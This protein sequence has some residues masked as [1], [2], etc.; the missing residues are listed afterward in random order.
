MICS[1]VARG[2]AIGQLPNNFKVIAQGFFEMLLIAQCQKILIH[3][4]LGQS[5]SS[6]KVLKFLMKSFK[7]LSLYIT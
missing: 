6:D 1:G 7:K 3:M 4:Y 2:E 5:K